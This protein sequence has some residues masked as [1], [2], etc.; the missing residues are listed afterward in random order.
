M[1]SCDRGIW[2]IS[3]SKVLLLRWVNP[4]MVKHLSILKFT[5]NS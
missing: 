2:S 5:A 4:L 1:A 3:G